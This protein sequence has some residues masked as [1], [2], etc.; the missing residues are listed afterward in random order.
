MHEPVVGNLAPMP[1]LK[2]CGT[3][4]HAVARRPVAIETFIDKRFAVFQH[5]LAHFINGQ[6]RQHARLRN[7]TDLRCK[8]ATAQ[9]IFQKTVHAV[10]R[11][12]GF[13]ASDEDVRI[14]GTDNIPLCTQR[15]VVYQ[16]ICITEALT[17]SHPDF[18]CGRGRIVSNQWNG[19][20]SHLSKKPLQFF[21]R[22]ACGGRRRSTDHNG[23]ACCALFGDDQSIRFDGC[24]LRQRNMGAPKGCQRGNCNK[25]T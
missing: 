9:V 21:R 5:G 18:V 17:L 3:A 12:A 1:L 24:H 19:G 22:I 25:A 2:P 8:P 14:A 6:Y 16:N 4:V 15:F 20:S 23:D 7:D 10:E 13:P 11:A